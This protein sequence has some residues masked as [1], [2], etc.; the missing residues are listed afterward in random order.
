MS[1]PRMHPTDSLP[2]HTKEQFCHWWSISKFVYES[3]KF[4]HESMG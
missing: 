3:L 1:S 2:V 4:V